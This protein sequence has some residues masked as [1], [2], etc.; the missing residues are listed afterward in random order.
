MSLNG[1]CLQIFFLKQY[2][3]DVGFA[4]KDAQK[5]GLERRGA[6][7]ENG[8]SGLATALRG[9]QGV[10]FQCACSAKRKQN[11]CLRPRRHRCFLLLIIYNTLIII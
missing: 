2:F 3:P 5:A 10:G 4:A 6:G 11:V 8:F 9:L 1:C 7:L